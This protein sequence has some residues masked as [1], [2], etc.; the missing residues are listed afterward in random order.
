MGRQVGKGM[1]PRSAF[2]PVPAPHQLSKKL[3]SR[4]KK[5]KPKNKLIF[6]F[7]AGMRPDFA[8][9]HF[10]VKMELLSSGQHLLNGPCPDTTVEWQSQGWDRELRGTS[11]CLLGF[12]AEPG[13]QSVPCEVP[14]EGTGRLCCGLRSQLCFENSPVLCSPLDTIHLEQMQ[15]R[16]ILPSPQ[17][18]GREA[19]AKH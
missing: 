9:E 13:P 12:G 2:A 19:A 6:S 15:S 11:H 18:L 17:A 7:A 3:C 4:E 8:A 1:M 16:S 14:P 5:T 10:L